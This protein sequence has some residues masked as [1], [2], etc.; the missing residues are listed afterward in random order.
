MIVGTQVVIVISLLVNVLQLI[1]S[2]D[3]QLLRSLRHS[4]GQHKCIIQHG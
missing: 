4:K 2:I 1:K 3:K